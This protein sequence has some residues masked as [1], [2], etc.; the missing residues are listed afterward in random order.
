M[1]VPIGLTQSASMSSE[2]FL[3]K[4]PEDKKAQRQRV[5]GPWLLTAQ[6]AS[7]PKSVKEFCEINWTESMLKSFFTYNCFKI[8]ALFITKKRWLIEDSR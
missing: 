3:Q 8:K 2:G 6:G 7:M 1:M 4:Q 5:R